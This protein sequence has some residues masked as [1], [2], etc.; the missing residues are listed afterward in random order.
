MVDVS[1]DEVETVAI[2]DLG[3]VPNVIKID[4][5]GFEIAVLRGAKNVLKHKPRLEIETH[6][7]E[8]VNM[9][10]HGFDPQELLDILYFNGY[11]VYVAGV[12][13]EKNFELKHNMFLHC[14]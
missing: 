10:Y 5:E 4:V 12:K 2:D 6:L 9:R 14:V 11:D 3:V 13:Q 1:G 8:K 7:F